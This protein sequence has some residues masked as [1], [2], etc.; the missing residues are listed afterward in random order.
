[1]SHRRA[2][3]VVQ[4]VLD[5][6]MSL[7][8]AFLAYELR[9]HG[10]GRLIPIPGNDIPDPGAYA[11]AAPVAAL[12]VFGCF[13]LVG[14]Y[15]PRRGVL[16]IDEL[17]SIVWGM[18]LATV[19]GFALIGLNPSGGLG[20]P[21]HSF[22]YSR[23]TFAYWAFIATML[24]AFARY[25][26]RRYQ[27]T[28]TARGV[29]LDRAVVVGWGDG[30]DLLVRRIRMFPDYG[31]RLLGVL[32]DLDQDEVQE[33]GGVDVI[34]AVS[35]LEQV[36]EEQ[37]VD[38]VFLALPDHIAADLT[39]RLV[40]RCRRTGVDFRILP[41]LLQ[42]MS[43]QVSA[44]QID[45]IPLI[46]YRAGLETG[47]AKTIAKRALDL[48]LCA[49]GI[50]LVSPVMAVIA[51]LVKATSPGPVL[52]HQE[53]VGKDGRPFM[54]HKFRGM[55]AD[56]EAHTGPVW[57]SADDPRRTWVGKW[58]RR[59]SLD[60]LPQLWNII[61]GEMSLVGPR[62]ERP[63]FVE[64]FAQELP[65]YQDRHSVRPGL[66]GWAQANDLRGQTPVEERLIY[67]LYYIENW[68]LAFD[69]KIILLT[70][71]RVWTHKNAY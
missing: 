48:M 11:A 9:F 10:L 16:F 23:V 36:V 12:V 50:V 42:L 3:P 71:A 26:L 39:L 6:V 69:V 53:R 56:A 49:P 37:R 28:R 18:A 60:E 65:R 54:Q 38:T 20:S 27:V 2:V 34:G 68:S 41:S 7:L 5:L 55:R 29:G 17:L 13:L 4:A 59:F 61:K 30:A 51:I 32:A 66:T 46:Q 1:M 14:V 19:V 63:H 35:G 57:A 22:S 52:I 62:G 67:D 58:I 33:V 24:I 45:G 47:S 44:D 43:T 15:R 40:E 64:Q 25:G 70:L 8:A 21:R 31:Y